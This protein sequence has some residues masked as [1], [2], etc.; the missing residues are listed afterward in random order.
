M[1]VRIT[2]PS[3]TSSPKPKAFPLTGFIFP[4]LTEITLWAFLAKDYHS[5][6]LTAPMAMTP[7]E[8]TTSTDFSALPLLPM[9]S[10]ML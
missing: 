3:Y 9:L 2:P 4:L 10:R 6:R 8:P 1:A 5:Q 7:T